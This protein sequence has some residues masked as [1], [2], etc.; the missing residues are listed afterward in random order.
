[1][2]HIEVEGEEGG[3]VS[4][5]KKR[6]VRKER[7]RREDWPKFLLFLFYDLHTSSLLYLPSAVNAED[8]S[9]SSSAKPLFTLMNTWCGSLSRSSSCTKSPPNK[10]RPSPTPNVYPTQHKILSLP[11]PQMHAEACGRLNELICITNR[12]FLP[13]EKMATLHQPERVY[14]HS[15]SI[16]SPIQEK[17]RSG[18]SIFGKPSQTHLFIARAE[19]LVSRFHFLFGEGGHLGTFWIW[20]EESHNTHTVLR[21][22]PPSAVAAFS[23]GFCFG[24]RRR[25]VPRA[26]M[27]DMDKGPF[28]CCLRPA[29]DRPKPTTKVGTTVQRRKPREIRGPPRARPATVTAV[30]VL[31]FVV[32]W[33]LCWTSFSHCA[34]NRT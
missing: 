17:A 13:G 5:G 24:S 9:A 26:N 30:A 3:I 29:S 23:N 25:R 8:G 32:V 14:T 18:A 11:P 27:G 21:A 6:G 33:L 1:M 4:E 28:N 16:V 22:Q 34:V 2:W 31:S 20:E 7:R 10:A 15:V 19:N 12:G